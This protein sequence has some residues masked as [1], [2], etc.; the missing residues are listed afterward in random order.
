MSVDT[1]VKKK[2]TRGYQIIRL[3]GADVL[4]SHSLA[5]IAKSI[6]VGLKKSFFWKSFAT[7]VEP[8]GGHIHGRE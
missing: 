1:Y 4:V 3:D 5:R 6:H 7:E 2:S 8:I